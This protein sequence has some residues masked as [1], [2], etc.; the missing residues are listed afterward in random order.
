MKLWMLVFLG[1]PPVRRFRRPYHELRLPKVGPEN[2][3][4]VMITMAPSAKDALM[5]VAVDGK[6]PEA[7]KAKRVVVFPVEAGFTFTQPD[8]G[9]GS[10]KLVVPGAG[11]VS[12]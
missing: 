1:E 7:S 8:E 10:S 11:E 2:Y 4:S 9:W 12:L 5:K 6:A 3:G